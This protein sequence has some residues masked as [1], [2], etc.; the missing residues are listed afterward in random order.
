MFCKRPTAPAAT[1]ESREEQR[2]LNWKEEAEFPSCGMSPQSADPPAVRLSLKSAPFHGVA[3]FRPLES[4]PLARN[5]ARLQQPCD[6]ISPH[7]IYPPISFIPSDNNSRKG[8]KM[9]SETA[10]PPKSLS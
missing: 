9:S 8:A 1:G 4:G 3:I 6:G 10:Q 2:S 5:P 7:L